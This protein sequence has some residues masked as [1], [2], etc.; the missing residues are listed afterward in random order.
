[1]GGGARGGIGPLLAL[2]VAAVGLEI[3]T[4]LPYLA[5]IGLGALD[6]LRGQG[7]L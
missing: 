7:L 6:G 4:L 2:A 5:G 3:A 1:M